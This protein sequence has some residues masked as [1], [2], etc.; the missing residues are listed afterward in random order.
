MVVQDLVTVAFGCNQIHIS[1]SLSASECL[2]QSSSNS[3]KVFLTYDIFSWKNGHEVTVTLTF[4]LV[5]SSSLNLSGYLY[6][7]QI[8]SLKRSWDVAWWGHGD[9]DIWLSWLLLTKR[10]KYKKT[11]QKRRK[12]QMWLHRDITFF[13]CVMQPVCS[14]C[15]ISC[16]HYQQMVVGGTGHKYC[17]NSEPAAAI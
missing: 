2:C 13:H 15:T 10:H 9:L 17:E 16:I 6:Y 7:I 14:V 12:I 8:N 3:Q 4:F 1:F 5:T 11:N